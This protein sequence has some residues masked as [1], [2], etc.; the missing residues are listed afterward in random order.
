LFF[1]RF[2]AILMDVSSDT[3]YTTDTVFDERIDTS[4]PDEFRVILLNDDF[5]TMDFVVAVLMSVFHKNLVEATKIMLD[6]HQKG[7]GTVG[8]YTYDL[9]ITKINR[10]HSLAKENGFP[11][12]CIMEK[13]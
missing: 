10:V 13:A 3:R 6:V 7:R 9:A 1:C 5:T 4:E 12:K 2:I 11:L 8:V